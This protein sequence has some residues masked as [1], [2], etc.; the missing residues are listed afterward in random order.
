MTSYSNKNTSDNIRNRLIFGFSG[1]FLM[2]GGMLWNEWTYGFVFLVICTVGMWEFY[3]LMES[4]GKRPLKYFGIAS[5]LAVYTLSFLI[6]R[7]IL[8]ST[9]YHVLYPLFSLVFIIKLYDPT[10]KEPFINISLTLLGIVYVAIPFATLHIAVFALGDYSYQI[11]LGTFFLI[12][13]HDIT[14]YF[15]GFKYG[16][17][18]LFERISPKKSWEG[19]FAALLVS[20]VMVYLLQLYLYDLSS[21]QWLGIALIVVVIGTHG[22]LV[23]S[24]LKRSLQVKDSSGAIPGHGGFLDRFDNLLLSAPFIALLLKIF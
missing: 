12:W 6:E 14:A 10:E 9:Y 23:E 5:G 17:T 21:L 15:I 11:I 13:I 7:Q 24:M 22:D 20:L 2:M 19:S 1:F 4:S 18:K 8:T 16:K 3:S